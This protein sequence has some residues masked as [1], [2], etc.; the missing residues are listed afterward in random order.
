MILGVGH[1]KYVSV[2]NGVLVYL[3]NIGPRHVNYTE[4]I[5]SEGVYR[6]RTCQQFFFFL[7]KEKT[8]LRGGFCD[9]C[10]ARSFKVR[11][12]QSARHTKCALEADNDE[13]STSAE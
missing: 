5:Y 9:M 3:V 13:G 7:K 6:P 12:I 8:H 11:A 4:D 1:S 2:F 10:R